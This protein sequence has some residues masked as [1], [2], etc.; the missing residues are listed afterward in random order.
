MWDSEQS[1]IICVISATDFINIRKRL[2]VSVS[3]G[4]SP[5]SEAEMVAHTIRGLREEL[6]EEGCEPTQLVY[7]WPDDDLV[8]VLST[9]FKNKCSMAPILSGDLDGPEGLSWHQDAVRWLHQS[10]HG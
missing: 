8:A 7:V 2:R 9:M 4:A 5:M 6:R 1:A 3:K 10:R